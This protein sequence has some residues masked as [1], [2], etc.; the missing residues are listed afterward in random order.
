[1]SGGVGI[2]VTSIA[3][4]NQLLSRRP[5]W[6]RRAFT[7]TER[8][9]CEGHP[10]R[11][12]TRWAAKEAVRKLHGSLGLPLPGFVDI[13]VVLAA[14]GAPSLRLHGATSR[15]RLSLSDQGDTAVAVVTGMAEP[16]VFAAV[17]GLL[18]LADRPDD[19]HKGTFGTVLVVG[20]A[21]GYSG[22]P[23]MSA[24]A[25]AR[26]GAG[27]VRLCVP[28]A[29][30]PVVAAQT[31][32]VMTNPL[33]DA[34]GGIAPAALEVLRRRHAAGA[35]A[36]VLGPGLGR[37]PGTERFVLDMLG[38]LP[39]P[40][41]VDADG[42]NIA[43]A[44]HVDWRA[45]EQQV[46]LTPH[47]AEMGRLCSTPTAEVQENRHHLAA[48]LART[49]GTVVVLKGSDTVVAAPDGRLHV[50]DLRVVALATG[51]SGDV[52]SGLLGALIA[53]GL[54]AFDAAVAA[55]FIHGEAALALQ[56]RRGRAGVLARDVID[57]LPAAQE[58]VRRVVEQRRPR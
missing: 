41:V 7:A 49:S 23:L 24:S 57:E 56:H 52:L 45:C 6:S 55:V 8:Q 3:R 51:G 15:L 38:E 12:A 43:A 28:E 5:E 20:G 40:T 21:V 25:A 48:S 46:V 1:M 30:Y 33:P 36:M 54:E 26:G 2:D 14:R 9:D 22:A 53:Q 4:V 37:A 31:L 42:L 47:P 11:W 34:D 18:R 50:S 16:S 17:P 44:H 27:L 29:I 13:E 32:E 39:A 10:R 35:A 19:A 58:R